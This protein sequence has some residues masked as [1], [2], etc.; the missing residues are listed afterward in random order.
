MPT[1][2]LGGGKSIFI[3][4]TGR[5]GLAAFDVSGGVESKKYIASDID[6]K[7]ATAIIAALQGAFPA[8]AAPAKPVLDLSELSTVER[9]TCAINLKQ[10]LTG[11]NTIT[12]GRVT[13]LIDELL[14]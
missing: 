3:A 12:G 10:G 11:V 2:M 5:D 14:G 6:E 1:I 9:I 7:T 8:L 4:N 13:Q